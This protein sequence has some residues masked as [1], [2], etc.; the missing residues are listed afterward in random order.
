MKVSLFP[1]H[2]GCCVSERIGLRQ[3][4]TFRDTESLGGESAVRVATGVAGEV[5]ADNIECLSAF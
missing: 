1:Q 4:L 3:D 2:S 5:N